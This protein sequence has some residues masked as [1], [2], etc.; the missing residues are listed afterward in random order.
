MAS[1]LSGFFALNSSLSNAD[2]MDK[3]GIEQP[4]IFPNSIISPLNP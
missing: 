3:S 1:F 2:T 4:D